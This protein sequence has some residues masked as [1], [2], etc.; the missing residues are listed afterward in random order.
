[1]VMTSM[2]VSLAA[3][4]AVPMALAE[5][6]TVAA[7]G[8]G[9]VPVTPSNAKSESSIVAAIQDA[10]KRSIPAAMEDARLR[11]TDIAAAA[12]LTLGTIVSVEQ[13][14]ANPFVYAGPFPVNGPIV[15][16]FSGDFC[17]TFNRPIFGRVDGKRKVVRRVPTRQCIVPPFVVTTLE[18]TYRAAP[19]V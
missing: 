19:K 17:R 16:P 4:V 14:D 7:Y 13:Q 8:T 3:L 6:E 15:G 1:M 11:A 5:G 10:Q 12:N 18:V 2:A 9:Q